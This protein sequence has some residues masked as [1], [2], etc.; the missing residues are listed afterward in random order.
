MQKKLPGSIGTIFN[1]ITP[2]LG[3]GAGPFIYLNSSMSMTVIL[4]HCRGPSDERFNSDPP[5]KPMDRQMF[6]KF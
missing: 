6:T 3:I 4:A 1:L 5:G 2:L